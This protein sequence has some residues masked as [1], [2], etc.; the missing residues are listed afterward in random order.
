VRLVELTMLVPP[1]LRTEAILPVLNRLPVLA[2]LPKLT[3]LLVLLAALVLVGVM[4]LSVLLRRVA[5]AF[6]TEL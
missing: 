6:I 3:A 2:L 4:F 1:A 5:L